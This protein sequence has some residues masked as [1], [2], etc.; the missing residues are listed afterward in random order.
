MNRTTNTISL[1]KVSFLVAT[2]LFASY[3]VNANDVSELTKVNAKVVADNTT[4]FSPLVLQFDADKNGQLS[5]AEVLASKNT[6]LAKEFK[7]IDTN[8]DASISA[9]EFKAYISQEK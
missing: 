6:L 8:T 3:F 9:E 4:E 1:T 5:E 2:C 7:N